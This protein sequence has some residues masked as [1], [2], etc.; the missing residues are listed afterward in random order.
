M[1]GNIGKELNTNRACKE[2]LRDFRD[3]DKFGEKVA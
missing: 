2:R 3:N 1:Q